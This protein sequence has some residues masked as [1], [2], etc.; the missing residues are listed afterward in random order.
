MFAA[1]LERGTAKVYAGSR[2][3]GAVQMSGVEAVQLDIR[4]AADIASAVTRCGDVTLLVNN[5]GI[6]TGT[7]VLA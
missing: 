6:G 1:L 4:S 3:V 2:D 7:S 5:A